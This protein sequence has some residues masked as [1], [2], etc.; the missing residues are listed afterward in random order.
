MTNIVVPVVCTGYLPLTRT[1]SLNDYLKMDTLRARDRARHSR[2]LGAVGIGNF[3]VHGS[4]D[5]NSYGLYT[6]KI[7][8]GS[9]QKE[10]TV[11][12]DTGSDLLWVNCNTCDNCPQSSGLGVK[13]NF[14]DMSSSSTAALVHCSNPVC[15]SRIQGAD[16]QCFPH[17]NQCSYSNK[18]QDGS[19][20]SGDYVTDKIY[21]DT[22]PEK[23]SLAS[24]N[25]SATILFGCSTHQSGALTEP[26]KAFDGILGLGP[27][28]LSIVSQ[29]SPQG[30]VSKA[31][32]HCLKG[33][34]NGGGILVLGEIVEPSIAYSPLVPSQPNYNL[35]LESIAVNGQ[36]LSINPV[37]FAASKLGDQGTIVDSGTTLAYLVEEAYD[38][39]INAITTAVSQFVTPTFPEGSPCYLV[40][41]SLD[42][43]P[44]ISFNFV[45]G[46]SMDLKPQQYLVHYDLMN[47]AAWCIGF[48]KME[49]GY[50]ILGD[51]VLKD[52]IV[53][54][55][56]VNQ[57]IGWTNYNCSMPVNVSVILNKDKYNNP[58]ARRSSASNSEIGIFSMLLQV[59]IVA[60]HIV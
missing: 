14:F 32:S 39:L 17:A 57:R 26:V 30:I 58:R 59:T 24:G 28:S 12:I 44:S 6:T 20:T 49:G 7:M 13:L 46:A 34:R 37:V 4:A 35:N 51:L 21:F 45:G 40:S 36:L 10:F 50:S 23:S 42:I 16:V 31:F 55:D 11:M 5:P 48:Q 18:F 8:L 25:S 3:P 29:L 27:G 38:P 41:T 56:L 53:V 54:Y 43:F 1:V 9:P 47:N 19:G 22:I 2:I 52:K 60:M 33:D 15:P